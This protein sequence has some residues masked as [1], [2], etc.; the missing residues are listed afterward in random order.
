MSTTPIPILDLG[1]YLAGVPGAREEAADRLRHA[2]EN[3][4]FYYIRGHGVPRS[5]VEAVFAEAERFHAQPLEAKEALRAGPDNVGYMPYRGSISRASRIYRGDKPNLNEAFFVKRDLPPDH[6]DVLAGKRFRPLNLWPEE[7]ALPGFRAKVLEYASVMERL[8][9]GML[10]L[11]ALALDM[12]AC[13][14]DEAFRDPQFTLRLTHYDCPSGFDEDEFSL[15]PHTDSSFMTLLATNDT[16]G[17]SVRLPSGEW[18]DAPAEPD[19]LLVN[20]GDMCHRW[21]NE[22]FLSTPHRVRN[23]SGRERYAIPFFFDCN[24]DHEMVCLTTCCGDGNPPKYPPTTYMDYM[25]WFTK[26]NYAH[27]RDAAA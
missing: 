3:V 26:A 27:V 11:Y 14:F 16:P 7:T 17:L 21:T 6:P 20:T 24:I 1:A 8:A 19:C 5:L 15:A 22:R 23:V 12:D 10:P 4:G 9:A 18:I 13:F 2:C 25:L